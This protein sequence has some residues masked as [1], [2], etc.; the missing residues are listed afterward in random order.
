[1]ISSFSLFFGSL[2]SSFIP[3]DLEI[4]FCIN[5]GFDLGVEEVTLDQ[6]PVVLYGESAEPSLPFDKSQLFS[7]MNQI[8]AQVP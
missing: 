1:M 4:S 6:V 3:L 5:L 7:K 8:F 2:F